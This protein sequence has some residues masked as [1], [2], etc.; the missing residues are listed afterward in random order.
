[1]QAL[2]ALLLV[3]APSRAQEVRSLSAEAGSY[4]VNGVP[5]VTL[6]FG[7]YKDVLTHPEN[8][9]YVVKVFRGNLSDPVAEHAREQAVLAR[10]Q[11]IGAVPAVAGAGAARSSGKSAPYLVQ[12]RVRG[13]DLTRPT[14]TKLEETAK[15]FDKLKKARVELTDTS[16]NK[17][18]QNIMV[19]ETRSGGFGAWLV[20][21]DAQASGKTAGELGA[22]Y[23][24]LLQQLAG[25]GVEVPVAPSAP[26]RR[27]LGLLPPRKPSVRPAPK[28]EAERLDG[29]FDQDA[30]WAR[31]APAV[32][33]EILSKRALSKAE[34]KAYVR[35]AAA[36]AFARVK[37][38]RGVENIGL[39]YN[40]HGGN[41][42]SYVGAGI[43][44]SRGDISL[45]YT[46][47]GDY[48]EKVY[49]FQ[50]AVHEPYAILDASNGEVIFWP[51]RMG[52]VLSV[53]DV[54]APELAAARREGRV[55]EGGAISMNFHKG[56]RGVP[57]SA[58]L[59]PPLAVFVGTAKK[60]GLKRL[61][62]D[63]E[64]LAAV[65]FLEAALTS[66]G[67]YVPR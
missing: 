57:Y 31:I 67:A 17:L 33:A 22:F 46:T 30:L 38:A 60:V 14:P 23:D 41:R 39:H 42:G 50:T 19:G 65:R 24:G 40:L 5:A 21:A 16:L 32:R 18:R 54:D 27:L 52:S 62:R 29:A 8:P 59:A 2:L 34:R 1:M 20:D 15:L 64:T 11:P 7:T 55:S 58:Y 10:L 25:P 66:G 61:S 3:C 37:A 12:E 9:D 53:F 36:E 48:N 51:T 4:R 47:H 63:E 44:A 45:R 56:M 49:F 28:T 6:G 13:L 43:R 26:K 35:K